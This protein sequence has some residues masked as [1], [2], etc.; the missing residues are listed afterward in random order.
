MDK[1]PNMRKIEAGLRIFAGCATIEY[2]REVALQ[3]LTRMLLHRFP[4]VRHPGNHICRDTNDLQIRNAA[5]DALFLLTENELLL[6]VDWSKPVKDLRDIVNRINAEV[7]M[8]GS[9]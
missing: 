5:T 6:S 7:Q 8:K 4:L 3:K 1:T 9:P 2:V